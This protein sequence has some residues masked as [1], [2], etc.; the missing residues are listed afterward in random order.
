MEQ[1]SFVKKIASAANEK[2]KAFFAKAKERFELSSN[3]AVPK[4]AAKVLLYSRQV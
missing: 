2:P 3:D 4:A 1:K